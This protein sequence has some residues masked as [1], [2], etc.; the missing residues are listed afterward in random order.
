[1]R[2]WKIG[3]GLVIA[4]V[5]LAVAG[6]GLAMVPPLR[7]RAQLVG[8]KVLGRLS[9]LG[10]T[11]LIRMAKPGSPYA[12]K[13]LARTKN[14]YVTLRNP[15]ASEA[16]VAAGRAAFQ[17]SCTA[18]H[19]LD[20][21]GRTG[22]DLTAGLWRHGGSDWALFRTIS[23]GIPGTPMQ[24]NALT[25]RRTWQL[26]E[27]VKQL[28]PGTDG[29]APSTGGRPPLLPAPVTYERLTQATAE[30]GNWLTYSATYNSQRYST[31]TQISHE[32]V[33]RLRVLWIYQ[34][35]T[36]EN[37]LKFEATPLVVDGTKFLTEPPEQGGRAER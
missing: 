34:S 19:G 10:W 7:W 4:L 20:G 25:E 1:M 12:M 13:E 35:G 16:D 6:V 29:R 2:S 5:G 33:D 18:C 36:R 32:N 15:Y 37:P 22:P 26:V 23:R 31:L 24:A 30:P 27:F 11:E 21:T 9:E 14:V 3:T 8:L 17:R 28:R